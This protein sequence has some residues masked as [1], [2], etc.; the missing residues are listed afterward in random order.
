MKGRISVSKDI[1]AAI[2]ENVIQ[3]RKT[4]GDLG[5]DDS[6]AG[7]LG[8]V[9]LVQQALDENTSPQ[10]IIAEGLTAGMEVV[11]EKFSTKEYFIPDMLASAEAVGA[12]MDIMK[13]VLESAN[14]ETKGKFAIATVKGD[15]HDIGKNIVAILLKGAG[16][17]VH[18][19]GTDV[20]TEKVVGFVR[21]ERPGYLGLSALLTTTMIEMGVVIKALEE[22]KLRSSVKVLIGGAAVSDEFAQEIGADAYCADAFAAVKVL[23][24]YQQTG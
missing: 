18:D 21:E 2:K 3:G 12:A 23:D 13:P 17:D 14:V 15:I 20:P 16:Y 1:I 19:L 10:V 9:E 5:I 11:G 24:S 8:V 22:S 7:T 6:L 4:Q